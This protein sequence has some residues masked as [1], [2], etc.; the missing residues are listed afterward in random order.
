MAEPD[1]KHASSKAVTGLSTEDRKLIGQAIIDGILTP[2]TLLAS[3]HFDYL[4]N[5][6]NYDQ[7]K[8]SGTHQQTGGGT[9]RQGYPQ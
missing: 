6:G 8:G 3:A 1:D 2:E 7:A 5:G 9:Y 4:Q